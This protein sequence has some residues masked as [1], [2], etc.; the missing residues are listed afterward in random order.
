MDVV[1]PVGHI[2]AKR[3]DF[4]AEQAF[5]HRCQ[6]VGRQSRLPR[7]QPHRNHLLF[8]VHDPHRLVIVFVPRFRVLH[9]AH[10]HRL[11]NALACRHLRPLHPY[12]F[13]FRH[14]EF[15]QAVRVQPIIRRFGVLWCNRMNHIAQIQARQR[16]GLRRFRQP[17][18][19]QECARHHILQGIAFAGQ[20]IHHRQLQRPRRLAA[21]LVF[22]IE[23]GFAFHNLRGAVHFDALVFQQVAVA[24]F[25]RFIRPLFR[26]VVGIKPHAENEMLRL[27]PIF[28]AAADD[29]VDEIAVVIRFHRQNFI[30]IGALQDFLQTLA[31]NGRRGIGQRRFHGRQINAGR[32]IVAVFQIFVYR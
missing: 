16:F 26:R 21:Q 14:A 4:I 30:H 8:R 28:V 3:Q 32:L 25:G 29:D 17:H 15:Q 10:G 20:R 18:A 31:H 5:F 27:V 2:A 22:G 1:V 24:E 23:I 11:D 12:D 7:Y 19:A 6:Q 9:Q 13:Q